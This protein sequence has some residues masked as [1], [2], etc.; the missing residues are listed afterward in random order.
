MELALQTRNLY[1][2]YE[3][4]RV[5]N[6]LSLNVPAASIFG[7]IGPNGAGKSTLMKILTGISRPIH[8]CPTPCSVTTRIVLPLKNRVGDCFLC[9]GHMKQ[10]GGGRLR[11][12]SRL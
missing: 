11:D 9:A 10:I 5:L 1:K 4:Q 3:G 7:L 8:N 6:N 2:Y 12:G